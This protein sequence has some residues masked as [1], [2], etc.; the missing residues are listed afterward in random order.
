MN[1]N[2]FWKEIMNWYS[3]NKR[4]FAWRNTKNPYHILI[5][6]ILLQQTNAVKVEPAY[7]EIIKKFSEVSKLAKANLSKLE[8][9]IKP[10][11]LVYRAENLIKCAKII[12]NK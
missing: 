8:E 7:L 11:G 9:I 6:E 2:Y 10:L 5:A 12:N 3:Y 1:K 4:N